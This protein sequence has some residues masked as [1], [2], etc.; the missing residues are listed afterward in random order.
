MGCE[1]SLAHSGTKPRDPRLVT[2]S[3][4]G[5]FSL[6]RSRWL[7]MTG[8]FLINLLLTCRRPWVIGIITPYLAWTAITDN[9]FK[10]CPLYEMTSEMVLVWV[11][12]LGRSTVFSLNYFYSRSR[13]LLCRIATTV[14]FPAREC[15]GIVQIII[16]P[17]TSR[18]ETNSILN[19][20][21]APA[22]M[23]PLTWSRC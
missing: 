19:P 10:I 21:A 7:F 13:S 8:C 9:S 18:S 22:S 14:N 11:H 5:S 20:L 17:G 16:E 2:D 15:T 1:P 6:L 23:N 4:Y 12:I 3:D